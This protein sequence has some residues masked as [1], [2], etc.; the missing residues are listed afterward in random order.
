LNENDLIRYCRQ[1]DPKAQEILY[2]RYADKMFRL[3]MRYLKKHEDAEDVIVIAFHQVFKNIAGFTYQD[4]GSLEA[5]IRKIVTNQSLMVLRS[6]HNFNMVE[7][8]DEGLQ[9]PDMEGLGAL[10]AKDIL[11]MIESLPTGYRTIFNLHV[12]EGYGHEEIGQLLGI[13]E[14]TSRSQLFKAKSALKK[15]LQQEGYGYGT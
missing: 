4:E 13:S 14:S 8:L 12:I 1:T 2:L 7:A 11:S 9:E 5:W 3:A 15:M 10:E 6:R